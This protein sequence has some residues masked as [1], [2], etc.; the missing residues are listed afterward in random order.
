[1]SYADGVTTSPNSDAD[2]VIIA[3]SLVKLEDLKT[4]I[5]IITSQQYSRH[6]IE[7]AVECCL[8]MFLAK[9]E[10]YY[11]KVF[12]DKKE[13]TSAVVHLTNKNGVIRTLPVK[14]FFTM[15]SNNLRYR[16]GYFKFDIDQCEFVIVDSI[17]AS[18]SNEFECLS[19][20]YHYRHNKSE[21]KFMC[22]YD[23]RQKL[24]LILDDSIVISPTG[25]YTL[26]T[27]IKDIYI[28]E[29]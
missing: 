15:L 26:P 20:I 18:N 16:S 9:G 10:I 13:N 24:V 29:Y 21:N 12:G 23:S 25:E 27:F 6:T 1:M 7:T 5:G 19:H 11:T 28:K 2:S 4:H 22:G 3:R 14:K 17:R 8:R